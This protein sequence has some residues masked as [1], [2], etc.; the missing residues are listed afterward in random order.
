MTNRKSA[1]IAGITIIIMALTAAITYGYI[2]NILVI[3]DNMETT[4]SNLKT[5]RLLF[6]AEIAG[7]H[8]ILLCDVVVALALYIFFKNK[9][10][11]LSIL[12]AGL[13]IVYAS[14]LGIAIFYLMNILKIMNGNIEIAKEL[15]NEQIV[16]FLRSFESIWSFGLIIFGFHLFLLGILALKTKTTHNFWGIVLVFAAVSYI[17]IH[18]TKLFLP[19]FESQIKTIETMLSLPMAFGEIGFAFW[20]IIRGGK[21]R[22]LYRQA[23]AT[24]TS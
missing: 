15:A 14:I 1:L 11:K 16:F 23:K 10:R 13:R 12:T 4:V 22:I 2:H 19:E 24:V 3:S 17:L 7:W 6:I 18:S 8:F 21:S 20:L 9:N 5:N